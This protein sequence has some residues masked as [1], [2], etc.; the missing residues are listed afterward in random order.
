MAFSIVMPMAGVS[1]ETC[2]LTTWNKKVGEQVKKG[3][4]LF[5][6]ETDKST[7]EESAKE[8]G[9]LLAIIFEEGEDV[10]VMETVCIIGNKDEDISYLLNSK[11]SDSEKGEDT[12]YKEVEISTEM[13]NAA[14]DNIY[15]PSSTNDKE[16]R[17][18]PRAKKF[19]TSTNCNASNISGT[20]PSCRIIERDV[21]AYMQNA[22][23]VA[24]EKIADVMSS[25]EREDYKIV[26]LTNIRKTIARTMKDSLTNSAQL[27]HMISF[28]ATEVLELRKKL[29]EQVERNPDYGKITVNDIIMFAVSRTLMGFPELNAYFGGDSIKVF[30]YVNLG[31]AVDTQ[32]GLMVPVIFGAEKM[33]LVDIA[34]KSK[35]LARM[36][37]KGNVDPSLLKNGTF[38]VSNVGSFGVEYF[39][40]ILNPP[41]VG[42][43]GVGAATQR[44]RI[45][46]VE[47]ELYP[48]I[49][50]SL[51]YDHRA[52]D[53]APASRFLCALKKNLE[54]I[55]VLL[56]G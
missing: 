3:E 6:Y 1:V 56:V 5:S 43:L 48:T 26:S 45:V 24:Q 27:T 33:T 2:I 25:I 10:K 16:K 32:R 36:C 50:L 12:I 34:R 30:N 37:T 15:V 23:I 14:V 4:L 17:I 21:R 52:I 22:K 19:L 35:E 29:K 31:V 20:G 38:T 53:G 18:S 42:I 41:Q 11:K 40:P 39:T 9:T 8:E 51:T 54:C 13:G 46:N 49:G 47:I 55:T 7:F 28:D 44:A